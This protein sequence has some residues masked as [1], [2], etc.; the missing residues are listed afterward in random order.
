MKL[1]AF[2]ALGLTAALALTACGGDDKK[3]TDTESA[4]ND[5]P[6][7]KSADSAPADDKGSDTNGGAKLSGTVAGMGASSMKAAQAAWTAKFMEDNPDVKIS[8]APEGSGP[9]RDGIKQGKVQFA[10]SD[11]PFKADENKAGE[12]KACAAD[13]TVYD[14]PVYISPV[15]I[16]FNVPGVES[17]NMTGEVAAKIFKGDI[18]KW[19]DKAIAE[20]N[21]GVELPDEFINVVYRGDE[22]GTTENFTDYLKAVAPDVWDAEPAKTFPYTDG[23]QPAEKT[24]GVKNAVSQGE[25]TIGYVDASAAEGLGV[26]HIGKDGKFAAPDPEQAAAVVDNSELDTEGREE[27]DI[28]V[29]LDRE[30]EGYPIVLIS[31]GVA[32][33]KYEDEKVA[34]VVKGYLTYITSEEGQKLAAEQAGSAPLSADMTSK[35]KAAIDSINA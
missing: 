19:N 27:N 3:G 6:A 29:N 26:A 21:E 11:S 35:V 2:A 24:D 23:G 34:E 13:S 8:Y 10:G 1:R 9:G 12:F 22:S 5:A 33:A 16:V 20:L 4:S 30:A 32:C 14:I 28:V 25:F 18:S 31:Y 17:I 7:S 15:A